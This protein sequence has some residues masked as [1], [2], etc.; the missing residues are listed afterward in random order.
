MVQC[1]GLL[2]PQRQ[3]S[4]LL[5]KVCFWSNLWL[6][7]CHG[8]TLLSLLSLNLCHTPL[9]SPLPSGSLQA[10][11][12][13]S[14]HPLGHDKPL[15]SQVNH[16]CVF[17]NHETHLQEFLDLVILFGNQEQL[18]NHIPFSSTPTTVSDL[19]SAQKKKIRTRCL[20]IHA[21]TSSLSSSTKTLGRRAGF[22]LPLSVGKNSALHYILFLPEVTSALAPG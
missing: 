11:A 22:V 9:P 6:C 2:W 4:C 13:W 10:S 8:L 15:G 18:G 5:G 16:P 12:V 1:P 7:Q 14:S 20:T 17:P 3:C 19:R 21:L